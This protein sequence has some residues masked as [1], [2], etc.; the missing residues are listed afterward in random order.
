MYVSVKDNPELGRVLA[1]CGQHCGSHRDVAVKVFTGPQSLN[2]YWDGGSKDYWTLI[3]LAQGNAFSVPS[4]HPHYDRLP[5]G[6][7]CGNLEIG[8][9]PPNCVL[10]HHGYF[11]GK[12][13]CPTVYSRADGLALQLATPATDLSDAERSMLNV[14]GGISGGYRKA[15]CER[16]GL[17]EYGPQNPH[18]QAL[19]GRGMLTVNRAGSISITTSGRNARLQPATV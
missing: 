6:D 13:R 9:L 18:V 1:L 15:E 19:V 14:V 16:T 3:D 12:L 17:G 8:E 11:R 5:S 4:S 2:S 10:V 7:R